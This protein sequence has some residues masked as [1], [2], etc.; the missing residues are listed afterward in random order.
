MVNDRILF[1]ID[2]L[3]DYRRKKL[4]RQ[5][6]DGGILEVGEMTYGYPNIHYD[7]HSN[8]KIRI[9]KYCSI[10][11]NVWFHNGSNHNTHWISTY[12]H[13][14]MFDLEGKYRDGHPSTKGDVIVGNDVWI[15]ANATIFSGI[16]I[17]DGAVIAGNAVVTKDVDPYTIVGGN[18][19]KPIKK[20]FSD[21]DIEK[22]LKIKWWEWGNDEVKKAIP[23]LC[24]SNL[25]EFFLK[26]DK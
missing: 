4:L 23:L 5:Y 15:G 26:Y 19:A 17:G 9:G 11:D 20:R 21:S 10:A 6:V 2:K 25:K 1:Y 16:T 8:T 13:R 22:L 18:P 12:P 24:S 3:N 14:I 7:R